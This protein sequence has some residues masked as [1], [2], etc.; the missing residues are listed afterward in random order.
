MV[1]AGFSNAVK[2]SGKELKEH[3]ILIVG[4]G[5]AGIGVGDA[6]VAFLKDNG[7]EDASSLI[8]MT[9]SKVKAA[10]VDTHNL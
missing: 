9:D 1:V 2:I 10:L 8:Y 4:A 7:V 6:L 3:K 5:S